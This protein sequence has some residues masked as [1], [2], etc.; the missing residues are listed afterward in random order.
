MV[1]ADPYIHGWD[2]DTGDFNQ[3]IQNSATIG[4]SSQTGMYRLLTAISTLEF[5]G[6]N[7][8]AKTSIILPEP[9]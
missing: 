4:D 1:G 7:T 8:G 5:S 6:V 9:A 2:G 3:L